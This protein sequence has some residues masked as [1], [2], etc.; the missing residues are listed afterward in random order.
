MF[1]GSIDD[2]LDALISGNA[3]SKQDRYD[4]MEIGLSYLL[5][6]HGYVSR[7]TALEVTKDDYC[8]VVFDG[9]TKNQI[10]LCVRYPNHDNSAVRFS[11]EPA[12]VD[13]ESYIPEDEPAED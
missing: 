12:S 4:A 7:E 2:L 9:D 10:S 11:V 1:V 5:K 8:D 13:A 6:K 3:G